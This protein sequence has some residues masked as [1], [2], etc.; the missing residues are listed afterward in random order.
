MKPVNLGRNVKDALT[1]IDDV[2][3]RLEKLEAR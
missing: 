1:R 3:K 2:V